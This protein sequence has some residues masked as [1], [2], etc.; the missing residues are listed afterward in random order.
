MAK[1]TMDSVDRKIIKIMIQNARTPFSEIARQ[2]SIS[3]AAI[4]QRIHRLEESGI[5]HGSRV[6]VD[7]RT[8]GFGVCAYV[9]I[10]LDNLKSLDHVHGELEQ[11]K[12]IV[13]CHL[14]TGGY[15][16]FV[17][18]YCIN[19]DHLMDVLERIQAI[20]GIA[21]TE[22]QISLRETIHRS[23]HTSCIKE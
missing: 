16:I 10:T 22:T 21:S 3:S 4:T 23:L 14:I 9:G 15:S 8:L 2:C 20:T 19:N 5:I 18:V 7:P 13:E 12:E 17:K 6:I 11:I 1:N